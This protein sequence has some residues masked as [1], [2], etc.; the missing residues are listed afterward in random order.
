MQNISPSYQHGNSWIMMSWKNQPC[1][2][3][4][5]PITPR[6]IAS[7]MFCTAAN[8]LLALNKDNENTTDDTNSSSQAHFLTLSTTH[9]TFPAV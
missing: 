7:S 9:H 4:Y 8:P 2:S 3:P 1:Y 6:S 5:L